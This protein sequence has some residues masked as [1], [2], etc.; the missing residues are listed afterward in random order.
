MRQ[1]ELNTGAIHNFFYY[2]LGNFLSAS[3]GAGA[4]GVAKMGELEPS[5]M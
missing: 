4:G 2:V 1:Y 3:V 5:I